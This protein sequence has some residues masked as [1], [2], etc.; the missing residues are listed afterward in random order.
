M[1][2]KGLVLSLLQDRVG[3][4]GLLGVALVLLMALLA[5]WLSPCDP[6][7]VA[8][9]LKLSTPSATHWMGTDFLGRDVLSRILYG[10]RVSVF[11]GLVSVS[12]GAGFGYLLGLVAGC[13]GGWLDS[14]IMRA[15]D[16]L[17]AFPSILLALVIVSVLGPN[18][19]HTM[20]AIG[21][22]FMP[23]FTR[24]VRA[25]VLT[26]KGT[27]YVE[28]ARSVGVRPLKIVL[29]H[30]VPNT[31]SPF[32]VQTTLALSSAILTESS[33]SFLGLGIQPPYPS[34]GS[35]LSESR[36]TMELAP[37]TALYPAIFIFLTVLAFNI[38]GDSLRDLLDPRL[39]RQ[40]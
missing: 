32:L 27:D 7:A 34:W 13:R 22:V 11:V 9:R 10:A 19:T 6:L 2:V 16:V 39:R 25:A 1:T 40:S 17:F 29:R 4:F 15:M 26:V 24:T 31:L 5:P 35:M 23:V 20:I 3:R 37:W 21:I 30:I 36:N 12:I 8:T 28:N 33:L 38:L 14:L 18:L